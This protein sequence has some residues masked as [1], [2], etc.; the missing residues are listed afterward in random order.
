MHTMTVRGI[1]RRVC[2]ECRQVHYADPKV[3]VGVAVFRDDA[4]LLVRRTM[5]PGRGRWALPGGFVDAGEDPRAA[6][7]READEEA[8]ITVEVGDVVDVFANSPEDGGALFVLYAATWVEGD[9]QP[10]DDADAARFFHRDELPPLAFTSTSAAVARW[11]RPAAPP[12]DADQQ[13]S[14]AVASFNRAWDLID[15]ADRTDE[16]TRDMFATACAS[17]AL[18][19][20]I[21]TDENLAVADWQVAHAASLIG[22]ADVALEFAAAAE[23]RARSAAL[24]E[25]L[26]AS[27]CEGLARAHAAAGDEA[28]YRRWREQAEHLL[29]AV[30]DD[31]DRALIQQQLASIVAPAARAR[32]DA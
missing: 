28:G 31:D 7:A 2:S 15:L 18:W 20:D 23:R 19:S 9:P 4:L 21:G 1:P 12:V 22:W 30:D 17:R 6:A 8:G 29:A 32:A 25:W 14:L 26:H 11:P 10:G 27:T 24:P 5:D 13:R 16:Q 3:A